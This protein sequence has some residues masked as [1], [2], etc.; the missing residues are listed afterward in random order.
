MSTF[1][2]I[3]LII[4][5]VVIGFGIGVMYMVVSLVKAIIG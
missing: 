4:L 2:L 5:A 3:S 1:F